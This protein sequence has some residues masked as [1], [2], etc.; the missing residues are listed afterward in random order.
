M[1]HAVVSPGIVVKLIQ[2]NTGDMI[3]LCCK[4]VEG[5][6]SCVGESKEGV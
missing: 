4:T 5:F 3:D 2:D 1:K 6:Q